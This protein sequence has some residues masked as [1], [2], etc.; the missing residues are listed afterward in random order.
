MC[1]GCGLKRKKK[2][3]EKEKKAL[4]GGKESG[5]MDEATLPREQ[6][7]GIL[8]GRCNTGGLPWR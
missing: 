3:K 6:L 2:E 1:Q 7:R 5:V 8:R 4:R